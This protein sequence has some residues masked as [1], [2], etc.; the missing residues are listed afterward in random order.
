MNKKIRVTKLT[1]LLALAMMAFIGQMCAQQTV[2]KP[3]VLIYTATFAPKAGEGPSIQH[4]LQADSF[5]GADKLAMAWGQ[6]YCPQNVLVSLTP[7]SVGPQEILTATFAPKVGDGPS[8]QFEFTVGT[9]PSV[10]SGFQVDSFLRAI[11]MALSW[12]KEFCPQ[13]VLVSLVPSQGPQGINGP[14]EPLI[15]IAG[16]TT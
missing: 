5:L 1:A 11:R 7:K 16:G 3:L 4:E 13:N 15:P 9:G 14:Q 10:A 6:E 12:G 2:Q 8:L